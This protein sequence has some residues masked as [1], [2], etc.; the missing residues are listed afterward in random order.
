MSRGLKGLVGAVV[1]G[2]AS[3]AMAQEP[4]GAPQMPGKGA[5]QAGAP[6]APGKAMPQAPGKGAPAG[7]APA[8][9]KTTP[10]GQA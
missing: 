6:Q 7:Q 3:T 4:Q 8:P 9:P 5:P 1:L 10:Q 2:L